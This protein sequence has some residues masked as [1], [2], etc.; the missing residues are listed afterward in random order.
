MSDATWR[1]RWLP[2]VAV[3]AFAIVLA[4]AMRPF[5][6]PSPAAASPSHGPSQPVGFA[7]ICSAHPKDPGYCD[8][9]VADLGQRGQLT[10]AQRTEATAR[11]GPVVEAVRGLTQ[12]HSRCVAESLR[13]DGG[14]PPCRLVYDPIAIA[15]LR[16]ALG[17]GDA[18]VRPARPDDPAPV[19][20]VF[21]AVRMADACLIG[22]ADSTD[23][24]HAIVG[25]LPGGRCART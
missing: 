8:R 14:P 4:L 22:H 11:A 3:G 17:R 25:P 20:S 18:I 5:H 23:A 10:E 2:L 1:Q 12:R 13:P 24:Q 19:G 9:Y 7:I 15:D 6:R 21:F 16:A